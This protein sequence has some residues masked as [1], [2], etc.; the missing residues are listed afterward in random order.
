MIIL[1]KTRKQMQKIRK[2]KEKRR[3]KNSASCCVKFAYISVRIIYTTLQTFWHNVYG[4][5]IYSL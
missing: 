4:R 3:E 1:M 2:M 5:N